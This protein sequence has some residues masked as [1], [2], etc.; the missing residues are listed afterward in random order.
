VTSAA[1]RVPADL[2]ALGQVH[3]ALAA[4]LASEGWAGEPAS[5]VL[6]ASAE[7]MANAVEHGSASGAGID[8][9]VEISGRAARVRVL[10]GG[11]PG[12]STPLGEPEAPPLT[13]LRGRGRLM[14][15]ALA[16]EMQVRRA[17]RGTEVLL[18]FSREALA[19]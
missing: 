12:S 19:A 3:G 18:V 17:G 10:D 6:T 16:E 11:R 1:A 14:M 2:A 7:A 13:S 15:R 4:A 9:A 5:R 8:V